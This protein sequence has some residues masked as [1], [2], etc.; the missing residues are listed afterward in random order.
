[1][2]ACSKL[3]TSDLSKVH[4]SNKLNFVGGH[5]QCV[6]VFSIHNTHDYCAIIHDQ[7]AKAYGPLCS[8]IVD[9]RDSTKS[10]CKTL[11]KLIQ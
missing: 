5:T 4:S 11:T 7:Q 1:M 3:S 6:A 9:M 8:A 10:L 2:M